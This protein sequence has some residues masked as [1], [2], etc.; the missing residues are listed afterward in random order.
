ML[1]Q[2]LGWFL[3]CRDTGW[4]IFRMLEH[5]LGWFLGCWNKGW[6]GF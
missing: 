1:E 6:G 4:V 5:R 3:A 2:R